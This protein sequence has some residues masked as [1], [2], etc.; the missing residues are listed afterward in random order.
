M[1]KIYGKEYIYYVPNLGAI[2]IIIIIIVDTFSRK[3]GIILG[4]NKDSNLKY[5]IATIITDEFYIGYL[6]ISTGITLYNWINYKQER[7]CFFSKFV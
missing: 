7:Y 5:I 6:P 3:W 2:I 1:E 4:P